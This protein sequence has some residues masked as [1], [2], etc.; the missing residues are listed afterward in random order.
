MLQ[1]TGPKSY[2][3][4]TYIPK[5]LIGKIIWDKFSKDIRASLSS[6]G[7]IYH[8]KEDQLKARGWI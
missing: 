5:F 8:T 2:P 4:L 1:L 7:E 3:Q 6:Q